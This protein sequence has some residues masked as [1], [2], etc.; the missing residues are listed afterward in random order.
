MRKLLLCCLVLAVSCDEFFPKPP[1]P[2]DVT[3]I[4]DASVGSSCTVTTLSQTLDVVL[5]RVAQSP[6]S[7][8]SL[9][10]V[11]DVP[12][13]SRILGTQTIPAPRRPG[14]KAVE[15]H[16][17]RVITTA[18]DYFLAAAD[19]VFREPRR[20]S[21]LLETL[22]RTTLTTPVARKVIVLVSDLREQSTYGTW[23]CGRLPDANDFVQHTSDLLPP[24]SLANTT[25]YLTSADVAA[26]DANRCPQTVAR[27][28]HILDLWTK[29]LEHAGARVIHTTGTIEL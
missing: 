18:K 9:V 25:V 23:E 26:V 12:E 10:S 20:R 19:P 11:A 16:Q 15:A 24:G 2:L 5:A 27:F 1:E 3:I 21:P 4:C 29:T 13:Q 8:V 6:G 14:R 28:R 7:R 22:A 17:R